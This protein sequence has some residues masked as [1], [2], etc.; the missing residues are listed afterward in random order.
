VCVIFDK[1]SLDA[2]VVETSDFQAGNS[3]DFVNQI[4]LEVVCYSLGRIPLIKS[5]FFW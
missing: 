3:L 2:A 5:F 1:S 4:L